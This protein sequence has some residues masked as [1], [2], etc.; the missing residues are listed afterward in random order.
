LTTE[1]QPE[2]TPAA[3]EPGSL[4][5][6]IA[7]AT[8]IVEDTTT[9]EQVAAAAEVY[10]ETVPEAAPVTT[11]EPEATPEPESTAAEPSVEEPVAPAQPAVPET[12]PEPETPPARV[13]TEQDWNTREASYRRNQ[14]ALETRLAQLEQQTQ[15]S[16]VE[17]HV[18]Q[19]AQQAEANLTQIYGAE[20]ARRLARDPQAVAG[21]RAAIENQQLR[22]Q[23][24]Q[25]GTQNEAQAKAQTAIHFATLYN[26]TDEDD[27]K[28]L[29]DTSEPEAMERLAK[30]LGQPAANG[31]APA[32]EPKAPS[33]VPAGSAERMET[34]E[35]E[36][37]ALDDDAREAAIN[38]KHP[39]DWTDE[40]RNFQ[41][42]RYR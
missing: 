31:T 36:A 28:S 19:A 27:L 30:R 42:R 40:D 6:S 8:Q 22:Q 15:A 29:A 37:P 3:P 34:G 5:A 18:E 14:T 11:E 2:S 12:A 20:E 32:A 21:Y 13:H 16:Q 33:P 1:R 24:A 35:S 9:P 10:G 23:L 25:A 17:Q 4:E 26:V 39:S 41:A 7:E 38:E